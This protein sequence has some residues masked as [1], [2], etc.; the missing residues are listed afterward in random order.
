MPDAIRL[1]L[2]ATKEVSASSLFGLYDTLSGAGQAWEIFVTGESPHPI[3]DVRIIGSSCEPFR[4][5]SG[6]Q[7][8]PDTGIDAV[9]DVDLIVVPGMNVSAIEPLDSIET[10][11]RDWIW[12]QHHSG[13][14]V[15]AACSGAVYLAAIGLLDGIEITTHWAYSDLFR[16][17][18][19]EVRLRLDHNICFESAGKGIV[20][21]GGTTAWQELAL[22]LIRNYGGLEQA[23]RTAKFWLMADRG[24]FQAPY[25]SLVTTISHDDAI[26]RDIQLWTAENYS[27]ESPVNMMIQRSGLPPSTFNRR[28]RKATGF[29]PKDYVQAV[30]IEEAKQRLEMS[31]VPVDAIGREVGY[32]DSSSFRRLFKRK[33]SLT[34]AKYRKM[35]GAERFARYS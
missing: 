11:S 19:P 12:K 33:T 2:L 15:V 24:E 4:C 7:I 3:F 28:F 17:Y 9:S 23:K 29:S 5:A 34:P 18:Y 10:L 8:T 1:G 22:F 20:T 21:S 16:R 14:R 13:T 35:F 30:R 6:T 25:T 32:E 27:S 26:V 31:D